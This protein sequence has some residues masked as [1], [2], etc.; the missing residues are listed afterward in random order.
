MTRGPK[1]DYKSNRSK[2][3]GL[4]PVAAHGKPPRC[5]SFL[6]DAGKSL[7]QRVVK[8]LEDRGAIGA[9]HGYSLTQACKLADEI[10]T[11]ERDIAEHGMTACGPN[12]IEYLRPQVKQLNTARRQMQF[13]EKGFGLTSEAD[14]RLRGAPPVQKEESPLQLLQK[15]RA[16]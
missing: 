14:D 16:S 3:R 15:I 11:L 9:L 10:D 5:P 7:W 4:K 1:P 12:G 6:G 13:Y 8:G 2:Q